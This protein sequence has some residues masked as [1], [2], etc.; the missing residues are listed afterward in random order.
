MSSIALIKD[1][2][3]RKFTENIFSDSAKTPIDMVY[4]SL[5]CIDRTKI[6]S[7]QVSAVSPQRKTLMP[8]TNQTFSKL[9]LLKFWLSP[10]V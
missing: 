2:F 1:A 10:R 7:I 3:Y 4:L 8:L 9:K 5:F 6:I